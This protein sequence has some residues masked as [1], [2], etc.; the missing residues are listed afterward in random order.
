MADLTEMCNNNYEAHVNSLCKIIFFHI[1]CITRR[2][3]P[4]VFLQSVVTAL[5]VSNLDYCNAMLS[6]AT[7]FQLGRLH[8][9]QNHAA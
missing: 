6:L 8:I 2:V 1:S 9:L 3:L 4:R 5:V 7:A